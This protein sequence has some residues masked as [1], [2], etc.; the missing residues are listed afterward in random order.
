MTQITDPPSSDPVRD[1]LLDA[2][3][4]L[5]LKQGPANTS[6]EQLARAAQASKRTLYARFKTKSDVID[7]VAERLYAQLLLELEK[8]GSSDDLE[9]DLTAMIEAVLDT[10]LSE[11]MLGF[12][13]LIAGEGVRSP[14]LSQAFFAHGKMPAVDAIARR[15][16]R[17][18]KA[19]EIP[20]RDASLLARQVLGLVK[21]PLYW[22]AVLNAPTHGD[23]ATIIEEAVRFA[24]TGAPADS[25]KR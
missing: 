19:G 14:E 16:E 17:A 7:A 11:R 3:E 13:R 12:I 23:R 15:L 25:S 9:A 1:R 18:M 22:P 4:R 21:E 20:R 5:F 8:A 10:L 2:A 24:M 6:M